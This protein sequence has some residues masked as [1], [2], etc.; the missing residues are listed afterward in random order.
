IIVLPA[1][2]VPLPLPL[3]SLTR[4]DSPVGEFCRSRRF[5][6]SGQR[7]T[8]CPRYP[9]GRGETGCRGST[10]SD[11]RL[12]DWL[13]DSDPGARWQVER[14]LLGAA[15][16]IWQATRARVAHEGFGRELLDEE[17]DDGA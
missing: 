5:H 16:E 8:L 2:R 13:L 7:S 3:N 15:P 17:D 6:A 9:P 11:A 10:M 14:D 4:T 12:A 1:P